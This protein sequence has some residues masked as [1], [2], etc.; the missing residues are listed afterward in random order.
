MS[1]MHAV[2]ADEL[3]KMPRQG[4]RCELVR[5]ELRT[6]SPAGG[7]HGFIAIKIGTYLNQFVAHHDLGCVLG[8]ETGF[9]IANNPDTVCAPDAAYVSHARIPKAGIPD[10][11]WPGAPD[12]AIEVV[13]PSDTV[14]EVDEKVAERLAADT[15]QVWLIKTKSRT[16][17][18]HS[19]Q[20][21]VR[22]LTEHEEIDGGDVLPGFR[23]RVANVFPK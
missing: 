17:V 3:W 5:G 7:K 10:A 22:T 8:A 12:L 13:S 14:N 4:M 20:N 1:T 16:V 11:Y 9:R 19:A 21:A 18:I 23:C 6:I 2:T 15:R